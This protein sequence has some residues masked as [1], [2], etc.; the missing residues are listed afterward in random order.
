M[1]QSRSL[2]GVS[3][4]LVPQNPGMGPGGR[5]LRR[6]GGGMT[7]RRQN[8]PNA[9][10]SQH[11]NEPLKQGPMPSATDRL[12]SQLAQNIALVLIEKQYDR[13]ENHALWALTSL[14]KEYI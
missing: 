11:I 7:G 6:T 4:N 10:F 5:P 13:A 3:F 9:Y 14:M 8:M 12:D 2:P 1:N